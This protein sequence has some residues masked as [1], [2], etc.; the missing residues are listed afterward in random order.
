MLRER[1]LPRRPRKALGGVPSRP[2][3]RQRQE[4]AGGRGVQGAGTL[5]HLQAGGSGNIQEAAGQGD[6]QALQQQLGGL[7]QEPLGQHHLLLWGCRARA[8][9]G[10]ADPESWGG[11]E[12]P[13]LLV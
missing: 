5:H 12:W 9:G 6:L 7:G 8:Q 11:G 10:S 3:L 1:P 2:Y 4:L 13:Y